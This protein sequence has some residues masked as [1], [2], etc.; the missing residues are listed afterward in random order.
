MTATETTETPTEI[1]IRVRHYRN[2]WG[3][4]DHWIAS[5]DGGLQTGTGS[6]VEQA[7]STLFME[8]AQFGFQ[9]AF[10]RLSKPPRSAK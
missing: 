5:F 7:V 1:I 9:Q 4:E 2:L 6:T 10:R 3:N 8:L